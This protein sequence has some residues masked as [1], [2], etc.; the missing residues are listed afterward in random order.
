MSDGKFN[1][2]RV[3]VLMVTMVVAFALIWWIQHQSPEKAASSNDEVRSSVKSESMLPGRSSV[4]LNTQADAHYAGAAACRECHADAHQSYSKTAHSQ[5]LTEVSLQNEPPEGEFLDPVSQKSYRILHRDGKLVHQERIQT[6]SGDSLLSC[7]HPARYTIGS[8]R[9]SRSYLVEIE[10]FL[11]ESPATWYAARPGW[12]LSPGYETFNPGFQRPVEFRCLFCHAGHVE[13]VD[14]SPQ[15]VNFHSLVIDC[16]RCHGPGAQ[17]VERWT[18]SEKTSLAGD[19]DHTIVNPAH[20][21]RQLHEDICAQCHLHSSATVEMPGRRIQDFRPGLWLSDF[22]THYAPETPTDQMQVVGHVEQMRLSRCY[23][24]SSEMTCTTCHHPHDKP[25]ESVKTAFYRGTC[26]E[27]HTEQAC[28]ASA[29]LR[30]AEGVSDNCI[31]CHMPQSE[32]DIPHFAFTHHRIAIHD[33]GSD[34]AHSVAPATLVPMDDFSERSQDVRER[35][36]G[37]AYLQ[38]SDAPGQREFLA[39]NYQKAYQWLSSSQQLRPNDAEIQAGLARLF[40]GRDAGRT[41]QHAGRIFQAATISP[42]AEATG[43]YTMGSIYYFE[44]RVQE[45]IPWLRRTTELRPTAD[46]WHMLGDCL[47]QASDLQGALQAAENAVLLAPDRPRFLKQKI[48]VLQLLGR[49]E[50]VAELQ[51]T[52]SELKSYRDRVGY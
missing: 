27:C 35:N 16:E 25:E 38:L 10:G 20:L 22:V 51:N 36:L 32:T 11:Y 42:E 45:A 48:D 29:E 52:L 14:N 2:G 12:A 33:A 18:H 3:A 31:Q 24:Q 26:L 47:M 1:F 17:H 19:I 34:S 46:V 28:R 30:F 40:W 44:A 23:Q 50:E 21:D 7:E 49:E 15:R 43:C 4:F 6:S 5:A 13:P 8:G 9:F 41:L 39:Q 37:L